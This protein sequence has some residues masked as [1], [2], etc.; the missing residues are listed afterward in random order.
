[1][2]PWVGVIALEG[3]PTSD[4]RIIGSG[5]LTWDVPIRVQA[6]AWD[7]IA[8]VGTTIGRTDVISRTDSGLILAAGLIEDGF[9]GEKLPVV[10]SLA[11]TKNRLEDD[12]ENMLFYVERGEILGLA[13][14]GTEQSAW[15]E[16]LIQVAP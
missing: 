13:V 7:D 14:Y 10:V 8:G 12:G 11:K 16:A 2:K 1:M 6:V 9:T 15:P 4:G 5:A 3:K